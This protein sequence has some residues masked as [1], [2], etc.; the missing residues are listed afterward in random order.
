[1]NGE[2]KCWVS[3]EFETLSFNSKRLESR[4]QMAMSDLSEQP[5]KSIWLASGSRTNAKA[6]YRMLA[7][8]KVEKESI[9]A[10]H[11]DAIGE[12]CVE[13]PVLLAV[14]DTMAVNYNGHTKWTKSL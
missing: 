7:N 9:L 8:E 14:Q 5:G 13:N 4:F 11:R 12:R 10:A 1:M 3:K 6:V 2:I